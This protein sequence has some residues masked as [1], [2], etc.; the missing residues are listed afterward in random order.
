MKTET[1]TLED[2]WPNDQVAI[3]GFIPARVDSIATCPTCR[4][5][6]VI[7]LSTGSTLVLPHGSRVARVVR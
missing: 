1:V 6:L 2:L 3:G 7:E 5:D 4:D